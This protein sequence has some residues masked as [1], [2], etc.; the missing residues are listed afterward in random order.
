MA[1]EPT[2]KELHAMI[3]ALQAEI[4]MMKLQG[5]TIHVQPCQ[6]PHYPQQQQYIPQTNPNT[7][8]QQPY[9]GDI[10]LR[11][12]STGSSLDQYLTHG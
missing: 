6:F 4:A 10:P 5:I 3:K 11:L 12:N 2:K 8:P 7:W 1:K 9:F